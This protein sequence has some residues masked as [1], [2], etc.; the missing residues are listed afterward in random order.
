MQMN[1]NRPTRDDIYKAFG[2]AAE[3]AQLLETELGTL[4]ILH[5]VIDAGLLENPDP[6]KAATIYDHINKQT[7]GQLLRKL[8]GGGFTEGD[9][10]EQLLRLA[11]ATRNRLVHSFYLQHNLRINSEEGREAMMEDLKT[12][13]KD[14]RKAYNTVSV[15]LSGPL[16]LAGAQ[17][18]EIEAL[19]KRA[20]LPIRTKQ[21]KRR[22]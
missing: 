2:E 15:L 19:A 17:A 14:L 4:L 12:I 11:L 18:E 13:E 10:L 9:E 22:S 16:L 3:T 21:T 7:L 8:K 5:N 6:G 1:K 20:H